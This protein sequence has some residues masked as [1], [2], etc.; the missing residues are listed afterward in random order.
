MSS[1]PIII[2]PQVDKYAVIDENITFTCQLNDPDGDYVIFRILI[3][4]YEKIGWVEVSSVPVD[5]NYTIPISILN[6]GANTFRLEARDSTNLVRSVEYTLYK[7]Q[8]N[9]TYID[10]NNIVVNYFNSYPLKIGNG[11]TLLWKYIYDFKKGYCTKANLLLNVINGDDSTGTLEISL[12]SQDWNPKTVTYETAPQIKETITVNFTNTTGIQTVDISQLMQKIEKE[13]EYYGIAIT[14]NN[15]NVEL[16]VIGNRIEL[17]EFVPTKLQY[18]LNIYG[19]KVK[20]KWLPIK[21]EKPQAFIAFKIYRDINS[22]FS[23]EQLVY[24]QNNMNITEWTDTTVDPETTYYYRA[25]VE[26]AQFAYQGNQLDFDLEDESEYNNINGVLFENG[27]IR[28]PIYP[29]KVSSLEFTDSE[30]FEYDSRYVEINNGLKL[31]GFEFYTTDPQIV[32]TTAASQ[33]NT[34]RYKGINQI[35]VVD[36]ITEEDKY[37]E[38]LN[39]TLQ[40]QLEQGNIFT[41]T[42]D[43]T[44]YRKIFDLFVV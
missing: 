4:G 31:L 19:N 17:L 6:Y 9:A 22:D 15:L 39:M 32:K 38:Q 24:T 26:Q 42:V 1:A 28:T 27:Y 5:V 7:K 34:Q 23:T 13:N 10:S 40:T 2:N 44:I 30:A 8:I 41:V 43:K 35:T 20:L 36:N 18:P 29:A 12:I 21:V 3:N 14:S 37:T 25:E 11:N 16:D 33:I